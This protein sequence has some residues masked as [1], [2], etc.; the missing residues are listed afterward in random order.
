M[1]HKDPA[2]VRRMIEQGDHLPGWND[3]IITYCGVVGTIARILPVDVVKVTFKDTE[4]TPGDL[5]Y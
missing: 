4:S 1:V 3:L 2:F 5:N